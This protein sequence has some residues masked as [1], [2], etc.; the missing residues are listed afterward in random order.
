VRKIL[1]YHG[2]FIVEASTGVEA[3]RRWEET[4]GKIDLVLTDVVMPGG[5]DGRELVA[6]LVNRRPDLRVIYASGYSPD[7]AGRD[8]PL[9]QNE[10][11]VAKP[12]TAE[13]LL[14]TVRACLEE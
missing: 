4:D 1:A 11:F 7:L 8:L 5:M 9:R 14:R 10:R 13:R 2:Y 3:L 12:V 6:H